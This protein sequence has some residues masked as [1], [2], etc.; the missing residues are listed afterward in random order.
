[1]EFDKT[2]TPEKQWN[3]IKKLAFKDGVP[4]DIEDLMQKGFS[5]SVCESEKWLKLN[6]FLVIA[7]KISLK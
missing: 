3:K 4:Q 1:M 5:E 7:L 6:M 2:L